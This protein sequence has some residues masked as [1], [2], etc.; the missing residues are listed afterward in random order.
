MAYVL[1]QRKVL[2]VVLDES[3]CD[4]PKETRI[5]GDPLLLQL[6]QLQQTRWNFTVPNESNVKYQHLITIK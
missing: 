6:H 5:P 3:G 1:L 4:L 2:C